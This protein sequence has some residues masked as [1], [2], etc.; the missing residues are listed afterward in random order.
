MAGS[1]TALDA[2]RFIVGLGGGNRCLCLADVASITTINQRLP[3]LTILVC[4]VYLGYALTP[5]LIS[6]VANTDLVF[7]GLSLN[8]FTSPRMILVPLNVLTIF[9]ILT[10]YDDS[11]TK[12]RGEDQSITTKLNKSTLLPN[13]IVHIGIGIFIFLNFNTRGIIS[14]FETVNVP[15]F[16]KATKSDP[17]N[18][19]V[20]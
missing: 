19:S 11:I 17:T 18:V 4:V 1:L 2:S 10:I 9:D 6:L 15:L 13:R 14:V 8:K 7:Y 5:G 16:L 20:V 3:Y 12:V